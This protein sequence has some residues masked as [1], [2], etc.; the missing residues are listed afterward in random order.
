M[1]LSRRGILIGAAAGGG[2][3]AAYALMPRDYAIPIPA[4]EGEIAFDSW[5]K[6]SAEGIITVAVPQLEMGQGITTL[7]PQ[8]VADELGAD[9]R[10]IAVEPAA[11]SAA[12][13][14]RPLAARWASLWQ[15][16]WW[17]GEATPDDFATRR[18][19]EG[20]RFMVTADGTALSAY[21][22]PLR[23]AAAGVRCLLAKAAARRWDVSWEDC[24]AE[25]GFITLDKKRLS[26]AVLAQD[27]AEETLPDPL[28]LRADPAAERAVDYPGGARPRFP[29]LDL[30]AKVDGSYNFAADIRLADMVYAS[31]AHGPV[32]NATLDKLD[33]AKASGI[34][35]LIEVIRTPDWLA[36]VATSW[37]AADQAIKAMR[38]RFT[39]A[40]PRADTAA[41]EAKLDQA[42][43]KGRAFTLHEAGDSAS[44]RAA[45]P[46][47]IA[48]YDIAPAL[49]APIET[50]A[51][52]ARFEKGR[53]ELWI[54][55]QAPEAARQA[56][57]RAVGISAEQVVLYPIGAGGS[58][59]AR[60]EHEIAPQV[61]ILAK[62]L[63]RPVQLIWSRHQEY[64]RARPRTPVAV[65]MAAVT[66]EGGGIAGLSA[67]Y[68]V[69]ATMREFGARLIDGQ[70]AQAAL[71][72]QDAGP[73]RLALEGAVPR[74]AIPNMIVT[75][76][77]VAIPLPTGRVR[78]NSH[79]ISA[80]ANESFI[81]ELAR[82]AGREP[83]SFRIEML[84][85]DLQ[86]ARCLTG[87]AAM[88][89]WDGGV[90]GSG[91]GIA[92][93]RIGA[94]TIAVVA[95]ARRSETGLKVERL[96]A[97]ADIG[98][99]VN[100]DIARQQIEGGLIF[101]LGMAMGGAADYAAGLPVSSRLAALQLPGLADCPEITVEFVE[102][103][104]DPVDPGEIGVVAVAPAIANALASATGLRFRRL[105]LLSEGL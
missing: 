62:K 8:V 96:T 95:T 66:V 82:K 100:L 99:I 3:I 77:P 34:T 92:C 94:G 43:R 4:S 56:A 69:P 39:V 46:S 5:I 30:P 35:G 105:P 21:E 17:P 10:Q 74:Y 31:V 57:A 98:R 54:A 91:M 79:A 41:I 71:A 12:Y 14:N 45:K 44:L 38:P 89:G 78:G 86:L 73:D 84:G 75:H 24:A 28:P 80:F 47:L 11:I 2:L 15:P 6:I 70:T 7:L 104:A 32:G 18:F 26:F 51:A 93:H 36:A 42:V 67:R 22:A 88:A 63:R 55:S 48:R 87:V 58:F 76:V 68:C 102:S 101:G 13:A 25:A 52:T 83:L 53:L 60:L 49:A 40:G 23:A 1:K 29:R 65:R 37:W 64:L 19:A 90:D 27:A 61:A 103:T 16:G 20:Q 59:D 9:W 81:D 85:D 72:M 33:A 50:A 97:M